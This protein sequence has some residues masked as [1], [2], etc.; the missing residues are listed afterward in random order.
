MAI[1]WRFLLLVVI[2]DDQHFLL[3]LVTSGAL[4]EEMFGCLVTI[5]EAFCVRTE[6]WL[7][8]Q[9]RKSL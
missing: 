8:L 1:I 3:L 2:L 5:I 9:L 7:F 6:C 4:K